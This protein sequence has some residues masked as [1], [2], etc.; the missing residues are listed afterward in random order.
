MLSREEIKVYDRQIL[1]DNIGLSGQ[2]R[3]KKS[4]VLVV[5]A[6]GLGCPVLRYIAAAGVGKI[7]IVDFDTVSVSNLHRQILYDF[8]DIEKNKALSAKE[9]LAKINP[10][11]E[12]EAYP[13]KLTVEN[14][15]AIFEKYEVIVDCTDNYE[16]RFLV[17]DT[18]V[19]LNKPFV[20][21]SIYKFEGQVSVFNWK[22]GPTYRCLFKD[23]PSSESTTDC[24]TAGVLGVLPGLIGLYQANEV[25]KIILEIGEVLSGKLFIINGLTN[26]T[27]VFK[28][29]KSVSDNYVTLL[30][31]NQLDTQNYNR[32]CQVKEINDDIDL[33]EFEEKYLQNSI[34]IIDVRNE[35]EEPIIENERIIKIPLNELKDRYSEIR[36]KGDVI[37][38]CKSGVRSQKAVE[39]LRIEL[40]F[41]NVKS[42]KG[43][44]SDEMLDI[45]ESEE[46]E[47]N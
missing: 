39:L 23:Y 17:N 18:C 16:T 37:I 1:L 4:K 5:G 11:I 46:I 43:G 33:K 12:V 40:G 29:N 36:K 9:K 35:F 20:Y 8:S 32:S 44:I 41:F 14:C 26:Q 27:S 7:G 24:N 34:Q 6:G 13:E 45:L 21:G 2:Q 30:K 47:D 15:I 22:G 28:I 3:L 19:L 38:F 25:L 31:N 10:F 42:L